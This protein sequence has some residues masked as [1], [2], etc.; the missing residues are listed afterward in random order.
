[1]SNKYEITWKYQYFFFGATALF[2][3]LQRLWVVWVAHFSM[4]DIILWGD[5]LKV[6][7]QVGH[8]EGGA[9]RPLQTPL[10]SCVGPQV[11]IWSSIEMELTCKTR[12]IFDVKG[13][14][15]GFSLIFVCSKI[16]ILQLKL[17]EWFFNDLIF[18]TPLPRGGRLKNLNWN[19]AQNFCF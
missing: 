4:S 12:S 18:Y 14:S 2:K 9:Q 5:L 11:A 1:M 6:I 3:N 15:F 8:P 16:H 19:F 17:S 7:M 13:S 10:R